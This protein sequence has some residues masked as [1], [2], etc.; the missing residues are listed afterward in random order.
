MKSKDLRWTARD[1]AVLALTAATILA[2]C[3]G[4]ATRA[5]AAGQPRLPARFSGLLNDYTPPAPTVAG[6]PYEMHGKWS[7]NLSEERDTATFSAEMTM[8]TADFANTDPNH[9]PSKLGPH[10]HHISVSDGVV[11]NAPTDPIT[12]QTACPTFKPPVAGGFVVTGTAYVTGNGGNPPFGN[13]SLV[14]IC[15]LGGAPN[16][17]VTTAQSIVEFSNFTLTF[18]TG[19]HASTHFG[20]QAINGVVSKCTRLW[21][22]ESNDCRIEVVE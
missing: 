16:P 20:T 6:G 2:L 10:T 14:T 5:L 19:S 9:D 17:A 21:S 8:E 18:G 12:W 22:R 1:W 15:V 7:L 3:V 13:P 4:V 11:H